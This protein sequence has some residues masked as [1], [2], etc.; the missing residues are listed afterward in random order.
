MFVSHALQPSASP[1]LAQRPHLPWTNTSGH[2]PTNLFQLPLI[3]WYTLLMLYIVYKY[4]NT[5]SI[6]PSFMTRLWSLNSI[7]LPFPETLLSLE[8]SACFCSSWFILYI[9][10]LAHIV[11]DY[12]YVNMVSLLHTISFT[13]GRWPIYLCDFNT[14]TPILL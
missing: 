6:L 13:R 4:A 12:S 10:N 7:E 11:W 1:G 14:T 9:L 5:V 3:F 8:L 2:P